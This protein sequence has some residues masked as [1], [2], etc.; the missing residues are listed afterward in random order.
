MNLQNVQ[1]LFGGLL[2]FAAM[3]IPCFHV[4]KHDGAL[5]LP[6]ALLAG[7]FLLI[8]GCVMFPQAVGRAVSY[9]ISWKRKSSE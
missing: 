1:T 5:G 3:M 4:V 9:A 7:G 8:G 6:E 2:I